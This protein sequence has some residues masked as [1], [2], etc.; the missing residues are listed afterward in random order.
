MKAFLS[1]RD[2]DVYCFIAVVVGLNI[3]CGVAWLFD[4]ATRPWRNRVKERNR[5]RRIR[6][7]EWN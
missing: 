4:E 2:W 5:Q 1:P 6:Q 7:Q 3:G